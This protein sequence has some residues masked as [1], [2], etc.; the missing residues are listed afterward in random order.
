MRDRGYLI[1][2]NKLKITRHHHNMNVV[3]TETILSRENSTERI[4]MNSTG[5]I[6]IKLN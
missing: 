4:E 2:M 5:V 3:T 1:S 6:C